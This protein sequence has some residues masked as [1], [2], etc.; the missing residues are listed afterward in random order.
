MKHFFLCV[1]EFITQVWG[2]KVFFPLK[3]CTR[4]FLGA[5]VL[6]LGARV[7]KCR[8]KCTQSGCKST[9]SGLERKLFFSVITGELRQAPELADSV[10]VPHLTSL[11]TKLLVLCVLVYC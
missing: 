6:F 8:C 10:L 5:S 11:V 9:H 7:L 1:A 4:N 3:I 2:S